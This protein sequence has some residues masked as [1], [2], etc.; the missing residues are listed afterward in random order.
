MSAKPRSLFDSALL[1]PASVEAF[2]K[3]DP[4]KQLKNPVMFVTLVG[5]I[6]TT[7]SLPGSGAD[8]AFTVQLCGCQFL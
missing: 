7:L 8:I 4:R 2:K 3:L 5:A 1:L 6:L